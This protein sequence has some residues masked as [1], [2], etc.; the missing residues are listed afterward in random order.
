MEH[1][2]QKNPLKIPNYLCNNCQYITCN[3]K[4]FNKHLLTPKHQN[5]INETNLK[6]ENPKNYI[7]S[8]G[9]LFN[10]R[11]TLWRHKKKCNYIHSNIDTNTI[12]NTN[13]DYTHNQSFITPQLVLE[14]IKDNKELKQI[15]I[16]QHNTINTMV[17]NGIIYTNN[18][19]NNSH[20]KT[21]NL[22][23][24]LNETC[25][26]AM[27]IMDFVSSIQTQL[28]DLET[29]GKLGYVEGISNIILKN[30]QS[31]DSQK[32]PIHCSDIK[33]EVLYIRDNNQ[34][35]KEL[36]EKPI[37]TKA[38]KVIANENIKKINYWKSQN[39]DCTDPNSKKNDMYLKII[40]NSMS[41]STKEETNKNIN[42]IISTV[43]KEVVIDK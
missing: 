40:S 27:N 33:R 26:D 18:Y 10:S 25:K 4:D 34:W 31:I 35:T 38:I 15:I 36:D 29:T 22:Q 23:F 41:G 9:L 14:L 42:K 3:K 19:H 28:D 37:L 17:K 13:T 8:C 5:L 2:K 20:N 32:R 12:I 6:Q 11:T 7:C 24:F 30:L 1:L 39:P 21:F 43:A 16:E